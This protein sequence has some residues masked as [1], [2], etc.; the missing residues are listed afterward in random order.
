VVSFSDDAD[1]PG[2]GSIS[3]NLGKL[4]AD[5]ANDS[6]GLGAPCQPA[7]ESL[8]FPANDQVDSPSSQQSIEPINEEKSMLKSEVERTTIDDVIRIG[9]SQVKLGGEFDRSTIIDDQVDTIMEDVTI[10]R[11]G[12]KANKVVESKYLQPRWCP[13]G[14]TRTQKQKLQWLQLAKMREKEHEKRWDEL[15][16][17]IKTTTLLKQEW[18]RKKAPQSS[19]AEPA[20]GGQITTS[21]GLTAT[22]LG[23]SGSTVLSSGPTALAREAHD[24]TE[25][26]AGLIAAPSSHHVEAGGQTVSPGGP[27]AISY[28]ST[29]RP[30]A[31]VG[32]TA[33]SCSPTVTPPAPAEPVPAVVPT[34]FLHSS[35]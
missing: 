18:K 6:L 29:V 5:D 15:F 2:L 24:L 25:D 35:S 34:R 13:P 11:K 21:N 12:E 14:L 16:D 10:D 20:T 9:T 8:E 31:L 27:T 26:Q 3:P 17:E 32:P 23:P 33:I 7:F 4:S 1:I 30:P 22:T 19:T 28:S